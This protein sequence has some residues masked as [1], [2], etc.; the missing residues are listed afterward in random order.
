MEKTDIKKKS[1]SSVLMNK[2]RVLWDLTRFRV[3]KGSHRRRFK[4]WRSNRT[5]LVKDFE[6]VVEGGSSTWKDSEERASRKAKEATGP[7]VDKL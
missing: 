4:I 7:R 2:S 3:R 5:E 1:Q 6:V